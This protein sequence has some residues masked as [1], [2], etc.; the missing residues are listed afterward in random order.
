MKVLQVHNYYRHAGGEDFAVD[1]LASLLRSNSV[2]VSFLIR[3]SA[4]VPDGLVGRLKAFASGIYSAS[5][6]SA[7]SDIL[8]RQRPDIVHVHN[9][10]PLLSPAVLSVCRRRNVP[11]VMTCHNY[12]LTCPTGLHL[13][14]GDICELCAS[15]GTH[16]CV[17]RNCRGSL[18]ESA[19]YALRHAAVQACG[20]VSRNVT[21]FITPTRFLRQRLVMAGLPAGRIVVIPNM[22]SMSPS[23]DAGRGCGEYVAYA[24]RISE[25]KG[26]DTLVAA[27]RELSHV[28][29]RIAG[30]WSAMPW[31]R[32]KAPE[33]VSF[34]GF[35]GKDEMSDF[36]GRARLLVLPSTCF[37]VFPLVLA[38]AMA[39]G[40]PA[41]ASRIGGLPEIVEDGVTGLLFRP[42]DAG[43]LAA[44]IRLLW[45]DANLCRRMGAAARDTAAR[46]YSGEVHFVRVMK[47]YGQAMEISRAEVLSV[48]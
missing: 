32:E 26:L 38:E 6:R 47:A 2:E 4:D 42:G 35:L 7:M 29:V 39:H 23:P 16:P 12:R 41:V 15:G 1:A 40:L 19:A 25:E 24:G 14:E 5:A 36:Y 33:N 22:T 31:L 8:R 13:A 9:L 37:E 43:D 34:A 3:N 46:E 28:P 21:L 10:Y 30:D 11:V 27:S 45:E 48:R 17:L 20:T 44:K 18:L